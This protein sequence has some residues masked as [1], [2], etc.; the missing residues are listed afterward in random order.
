MVCNHYTLDCKIHTMK[1]WFG[2]TSA[3]ILKYYPYYSRIRDYIREK[4]NEIL[5]DWLNNAYFSVKKLGINRKRDIKEIYKQVIDA[6]DS[7][8]VCIIEYTI[9]NFSSS[10]QITYALQKRKPTLVMRLQK[11][12]K[13]FIGSYLD[14]IDSEYLVVENY[15]LKNYKKIIDNFLQDYAPKE[16]LKRYNIVLSSRHNQYLNQLCA[17]TKLSR[18]EVIRQAIER[19]M[20]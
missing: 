16:N 7:A 5:F 10:H 1:V 4:N 13:N 2:T 11:D 8:D 15:N 3:E 12:N 19:M 9:P 18:S 20:E 6:I 14:A 17:K